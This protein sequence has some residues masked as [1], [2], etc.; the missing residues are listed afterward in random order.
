MASFI[1]VPQ[2]RQN[3]LVLCIKT[4]P[5]LACLSGLISSNK[6]FMFLHLLPTEAQA[7]FEVDSLNMLVKK[8]QSLKYV[9]SVQEKSRWGG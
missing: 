4:V 8:V 5:L 6:Q 2:N 3:E 7:H 9:I 1:I